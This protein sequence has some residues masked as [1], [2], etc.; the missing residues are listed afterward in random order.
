MAIPFQNFDFI[1][2]DKG[3]DSKTDPHLT[4]ELLS[5]E[6]AIAPNPGAW[7]KR[8]GRT[9]LSINVLG[10]GTL[11][12]SSSTEL[13]VLGDELLQINADT[14]YG[15][16]SALSKWIPRSA[17]QD[18]PALK[19]ERKPLTQGTRSASGAD[20]CTVSGVTLTAWTQGT[21]EVHV[22]VTDNATGAVLL[23]DT[24]VSAS[25][26]QQPRCVALGAR[27]YV[28]YCG[29]GNNNL[30][31]RH[32]TALAP[33]TLSSEATVATNAA[34]S[35]N[36]L[37]VA[38]VSSSVAVLAYNSSTAATSRVALY[39]S[40]SD[41]ITSSTTFAFATTEIS[42]YYHAALDDI[43]IAF[44]EGTNVKILQLNTDL[45]VATA[46]TVVEAAG[47]DTDSYCMTA[48]YGATANSVYLYYTNGTAL[49]AAVGAAGTY[50]VSSLLRRCEPVAKPFV[51]A[52][53]RIVLPIAVFGEGY[54]LV[55]GVSGNVLASVLNGHAPGSSAT[56][57]ANCLAISSTEFWIPLLEAV[58]VTAQDSTL[59]GTRGVTHVVVTFDTSETTQATVGATRF[60]ARG[61]LYE[62]DGNSVFEAG[63]LLKP[64][65]STANG[66]AGSVANGTYSLIAVHDWNDA[67]GQRHLSTP[68]DP[69][70]HVASGANDS[71]EGTVLA[72]PLTRKTDSAFGNRQDFMI[73]GYSTE[74]GAT[75]YY[76]FGHQSAAPVTGAAQYNDPAADTQ[77]DRYDADAS[78]TGN[79][80]LYTTGGVLPNDTPPATNIIWPHKNRLWL[81][82]SEYPESLW[83]SKKHVTGSAVSF[84]AFLEIKLAD[85]GGPITAG[86]SLD[87]KCIIFKRSAIYYIAG[88]GP[89]PTGANNSWSEPILIAADVGCTNAKSV[90]LTPNGIMFE[91]AKGIYLLDRSLSVSHIGAAVASYDSNTITA[92]VLVDDANQVRFFTSQGYTLVYDYYVGK[93]GV[94]TG[95]FQQ[96]VAAIAGE[97]AVYSL[98]TNGYVRQESSAVYDDDTNA[99]AL[100]VGTGWINVAGINGFQ[101]V[102]KVQVT[103]KYYSAHTLRLRV[104]YDDETTYTDYTKATSTFVGADNVYEPVFHLARQKCKRIRFVITEDTPTTGRAMALTGLTLLVGVKKGL[105]KAAAAK[106]T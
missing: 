103:G 93:W 44:E 57:T 49:R 16:S 32:I 19:L 1:F 46:I 43:F 77:Y 79:E 72:S 20:S 13:S 9:Q 41:T 4:T 96:A 66:T 31:E 2:G 63:F 100:S 65:L 81:V 45:T 60:F 73:V 55:D 85:N 35:N 91:S 87:D 92:A 83:P 74:A 67:K 29:N 97:G 47:V 89:D 102:Q 94:H 34:T 11:T 71:I 33:Q 15:Y 27:L 5:L 56:I 106:H 22:M 7:E 14:L 50:S 21:N 82:P 38:K 99:Y 6:N 24:A 18:I 51:Q 90:V 28:F 105:R 52:S 61:L 17:A 80:Y 68:S 76:R 95:S 58:R 36:V 12:N 42:A 88:D 62:Y 10:G 53:E 25:Q 59:I 86:A 48:G 30:Y 104:Y 69:V 64:S 3:L 98:D 84:S 39:S 70:E 101:R 37:D 26:R 23:A 78:I 54:F 8:Y 75:T 40:S